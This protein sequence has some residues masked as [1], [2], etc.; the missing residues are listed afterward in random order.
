MRDAILVETKAVLC[1]CN[2]VWIK[3]VPYPER[4]GILLSMTGCLR[5]FKDIDLSLPK[6]LPE[7][8]RSSEFYRPVST[9]NQNDCHPNAARKLQPQPYHSLVCAA[10]LL[11]RAQ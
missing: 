4:E 6:L 3:L 9:L 8:T 5:V 10:A 11:C 1:I 7:C 2:T